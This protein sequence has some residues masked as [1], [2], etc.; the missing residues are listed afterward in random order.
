MLKKYFTLIP[1]LLGLSTGLKGMNLEVLVQ[2]SLNTPLENSFVVV[3]GIS[4]PNYLEIQETSE[5]GL[6]NFSVPDNAF[7]SYSAFKDGYHSYGGAF[8]SDEDRDI[9]ITLSP[10]EDNQWYDYYT[11]DGN[12]EF[13]FSSSDEDINYHVGDDFNYEIEF[14][15]VSNQIVSFDNNSLTSVVYDSSGNSIDGFG[16]QNPDLNYA[17]NLHPGI[18]WFNASAQGNNV[19]VYIGGADGNINGRNFNISGE[20]EWVSETI[21]TNDNQINSELSG[22]YNVD[23]SLNYFMNGNPNNIGISSQQ[24]YVNNPISSIKDGKNLEKKVINFPNPSNNLFYVKSDKVS[25]LDLYNICGQ[26]I[27]SEEGKYFCFSDLSSG[28]YIGEIDGVKFKQTILK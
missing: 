3:G 2:D 12:V 4:N 13:S 11:W 27:Y 7:Y 15:N 24:F 14:S 1:L 5:D 26:K 16:E 28:V 20:N 10:F 9:S 8:Y 17:I 21:T 19:T 6:A 23:V 22:F 25:T 18:G